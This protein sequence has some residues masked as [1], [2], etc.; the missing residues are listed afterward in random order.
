MSVDSEVRTSRGRGLGVRWEGAIITQEIYAAEAKNT[1]FIPVLLS[2]HSTANIPLVLRGSS[3]Y[4]LYTPEGYDLLYRRVTHQ[5]LIVKP[6]LGSRRPMP[7]RER[8]L[9]MSLEVAALTSPLTPE[10]PGV[11]AAQAPSKEGSEREGSGLT[12]LVG[13]R[14][15]QPTPSMQ[16][17]QLYQGEQ[18]LTAEQQAP[19]T[20]P[21]QEIHKQR[22]AFLR[23]G[24]WVATILVLLLLGG[25]GG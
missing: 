21:H 12:G 22:V 6:E 1:V 11:E 14:V 18:V 20:Q 9:S 13:T 10:Q 15:E 19:Q 25:F 4:E 17:G 7:P 24:V 16:M 2:P 23:R 3:Y 8:T 5:P